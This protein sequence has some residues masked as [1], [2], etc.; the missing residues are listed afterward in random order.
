MRQDKEL[1][2]KYIVALK[3]VKA[4]KTENKLMHLTLDQVEGIKQ[5]LYSGDNEQLIRIVSW[6]QGV[7]IKEVY[8]I[9]IVYFYG[10]VNSVKEQLEMIFKAES[11][12]SPSDT[13]IKWEMV[14]G[15]RKMAKFGIINTLEKLNG[16]DILKDEQILNLKYSKVFGTL[17]KRSTQSDLDSQMSKIKIKTE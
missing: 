11:Q 14:E 9:K 12:L 13:N 2:N 5:N 17:L 7:D 3:Y 15:S 6:V 1:V 8:K 4:I 16:G 10:I